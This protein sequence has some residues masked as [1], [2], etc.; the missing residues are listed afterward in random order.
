[1]VMTVMEELDK[2]NHSCF[3]RVL[4]FGSECSQYNKKDFCPNGKGILPIGKNCHAVLLTYSQGASL[5]DEST[6]KVM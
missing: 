2:V 3:I 6:L 4:Q 5:R 1:M